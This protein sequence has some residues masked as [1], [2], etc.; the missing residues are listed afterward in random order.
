MASSLV[1]ATLYW[2]RNPY[3]LCRTRA[4][5]TKES[6]F[7]KP[8]LWWLIADSHLCPSPRL[9]VYMY[10]TKVVVCANY[11]SLSVSGTSVYVFSVYAI[12]SLLVSHLQVFVRASIGVNV[13]FRITVIVCV[14][15]IASGCTRSSSQ[16]NLWPQRFRTSLFRDSYFNRIVLIWNNLP[17][18]IR[19]CQSYSTFKAKLY[20]YYY[21]KLDNDF[22]PDRPRTWK[23]ICPNCRT[24]NRIFCCWVSCILSVLNV[25]LSM[26]FG[27]C[28][29]GT[30]CPFADP[31]SL[32]SYLL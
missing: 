16:L 28:L 17:L 8:N 15:L 29:A 31:S 14:R 1:Q 27:V 32:L 10:G 26:Y 4:R 5:A 9:T 24:V 19:Q 2:W 23:T 11:G 3:L 22:D 12:R 7:F 25:M 30:S 18:V 20:K 21:D 13:S 6:F